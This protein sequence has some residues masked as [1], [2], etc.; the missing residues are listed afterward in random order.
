MAVLS[1]AAAFS[2]CSTASRLAGDAYRFLPFTGKEDAAPP[3][4]VAVKTR[5]LAMTMEF[6]PQTVRLSDDRQVEVKIRLRNTSKRFVQLQF[7]TTQ[8]IEILVHGEGG[9]L[10]T[11]WSEDRSFDPAPSYV[12]INPG[13]HVEYATFIPT[14]DMQAGKPYTVT[15]FFP[16]HE[17]LKAEKVLTPEA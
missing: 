4:G 11:Q 17:E 14:R 15:G 2:G 10:V 6:K 7:P 13:E 5:N 9:K 3:G 8:R 16:H 1:L 12:S